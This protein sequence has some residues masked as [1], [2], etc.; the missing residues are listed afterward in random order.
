VHVPTALHPDPDT[1]RSWV[2][3]ELSRSEYHQSLLERLYGWLMEQWDR[4]QA[5][6][7]GASPLSTAAA[8]VVVTLLVVAVVLVASRVRRDPVRDPGTGVGP[9]DGL[10]SADEHRRAAVSALESRRHDVALVEAFR[11]IAAR[12]VQRGVLE[13]RPGLT[14]HEL[15]VGLSPFFPDHVDAL[16]EASTM[17]DLVYYGDLPPTGDDARSV[18]ELDDALRV[19]RPARV[20]PGEQVGALLR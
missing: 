13:E 18:L 9:V 20:A 8:A 2:E 19:A 16:A 4:L 15:T 11:A 6:A 14:A 12:A 10:M 17:F 7:L 1:A 3:R 5:A